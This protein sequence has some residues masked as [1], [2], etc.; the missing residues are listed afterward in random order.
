MA[1]D[2]RLVAHDTSAPIRGWRQE[3]LGPPSCWIGEGNRKSSWSDLILRQSSRVFI[4]FCEAVQ[5]LVLSNRELST[6]YLAYE[7]VYLFRY[8]VVLV[9]LGAV[10]VLFMQQVLL[11]KFWREFSE[12]PVS[13]GSPHSVWI[14]ASSTINFDNFAL[15]QHLSSGS[16]VFNLRGRSMILVRAADFWP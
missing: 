1:G 7:G 4:R 10:P 13:C 11:G 14:L 6:R 9:N 2:V 12:V 3:P 15:S 8:E 5:S 16:S